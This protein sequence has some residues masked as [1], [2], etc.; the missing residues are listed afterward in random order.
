M[1]NQSSNHNQIDFEALARQ[2]LAAHG[3]QPAFSPAVE[4]QLAALRAHSPAVQATA[5]IRDMRSLL[6]SSIDNDTSKDLDQI[7]YAEKQPS[8]DTRVFIGVADVDAYVP[9]GT[10]IDEE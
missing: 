6:W 4:Q 10:P 5:E 9:M 2:S 3:F 1:T 7:E 8:G